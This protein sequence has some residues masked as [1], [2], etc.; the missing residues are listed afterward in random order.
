[1]IFLDSSAIIA[2]KNADDINHKK[3]ADIFQKLN[4]GDYGVGVISEFVFSEVTTV[5]ALRKS[6]EAAKEVGNVLLEAREIE[7]MRASEVF[8]RS[9]EIFSNQENTGLSFVDASNLACME[10]RKIRKIATF[11]KDFVK[12]RSVEVVNG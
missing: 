8:E 2:Y 1:M 7:I 5:L 3:A 9:W 6:M 12:I 10:M 11:D 4:A